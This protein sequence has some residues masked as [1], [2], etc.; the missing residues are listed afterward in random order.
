MMMRNLFDSNILPVCS[1]GLAVLA[2]PLSLPPLAIAAFIIGSA[3]LSF[4]RAW[5]GL[6]HAQINVDFLD[7]LAALSQPRRLSS[8]QR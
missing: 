7:A 5:S 2:G 8:V 4:R 1:L 3:H 6:K